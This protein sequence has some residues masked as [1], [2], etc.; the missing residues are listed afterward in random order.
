MLMARTDALTSMPNRLAFMEG[1]SRES[2]RALR[3]R[4]PM[5][6][7]YIDLDNFKAVNDPAGA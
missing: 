3:G 1:A 6:V 2:H 7:A 5:S 4:S